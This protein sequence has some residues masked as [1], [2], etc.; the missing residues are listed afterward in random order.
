MKK[1]WCRGSL[2]PREVTNDHLLLKSG[3]PGRLVCGTREQ[4]REGPTR[5]SVTEQILLHPVDREAERSGQDQR[6]SGVT[7]PQRQRQ[8]HSEHCRG[9]RAPRRSRGR[10]RGT[11]WGQSGD[12]WGGC[13]GP[14]APKPNCLGRSFVSENRL[15]SDC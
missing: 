3:K 2:F 4:Q 9:E 13:C 11:V 14:L 15:G 8:R 6:S 1:S 7:R 12:A 5:S 10:G